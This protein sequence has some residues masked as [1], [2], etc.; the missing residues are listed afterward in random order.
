MIDHNITQTITKDA[1][2]ST[3]I[4]IN[5]V[6][7]ALLSAVGDM[8][9]GAKRTMTVIN[10][11]IAVASNLVLVLVMSSLPFETGEVGEDVYGVGSGV[12]G[13]DVGATG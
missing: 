9:T 10:T 6:P 3:I 5:A 11:R 8:A 7:I 1:I 13:V 2:R 12:Y 4:W